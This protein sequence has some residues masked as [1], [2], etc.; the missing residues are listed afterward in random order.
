MQKAVD[1]SNKCLGEIGLDRL[2]V[3]V[4]MKYVCRYYKKCGGGR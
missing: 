4:G 2:E 1:G 3:D